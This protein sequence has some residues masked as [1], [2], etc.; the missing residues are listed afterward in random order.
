MQTCVSRKRNRNETAG[1]LSYGPIDGA[2][3]AWRRADAIEATLK[4]RK[5]QK[6]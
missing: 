3:V 2:A 4:F 1:A 6:H 5:L